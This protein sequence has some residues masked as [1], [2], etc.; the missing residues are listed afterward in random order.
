ML[1]LFSLPALADQ[2]ECDGSF[3]LNRLI[4]G[5]E[6]VEG[7]LA[8]GIERRAAEVLTVL[9]EG[10]ACLED[11]VHPRH[12]VRYG[13]ARALLAFARADE[14]ELRYWGQLALLDP[15]VRWP[16]GLEVDHPARE[17]LATLHPTTPLRLEHRGLSAPRG[18]AILID[19][20]AR[21]LPEA[22]PDAPHLVQIIDGSGL[23]VQTLWQDGV[24][25]SEALLSDTPE[26]L[27]IPWACPPPDPGLDP[28]AP[29]RISPE[30]AARRA[31]LRT[32]QRV[33]ELEARQ[34][35][36]QA[37][38]RE[39][40]RAERRQARLERRNASDGSAPVDDGAGGAPRW[41]DV[42]LE[43]V[44]PR[45]DPLEQGRSTQGC[46][47]LLLLE[48]RSMLGRLTEEQILCLQTRLSTTG[49]QTTRS[50]ISRILVA[51][52]WSRGDDHRWS[53]AIRRHLEQIDRSDADLCYLFARWLAARASTDPEAIRW[54][55]LA[56]DN[57]HRWEG[58]RRIQRVDA[59]HRIRTVVAQ[60][61]W[62]D[63]ETD[64]LQQ[65]T[66]ERIGRATFW[67]NQTKTLAR[68]WLQFALAAG[69]DS[70]LPYELCLSAA[71]TTE[72]CDLV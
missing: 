56:L 62:L 45:R 52:A 54:A 19:G 20:T 26:P 41:V 13:R 11:P 65:R 30:E 42:Y 38:Q 9:H 34:Q 29:I 67:R 49:A 63:A 59:L 22:S 5:L 58:P 50:A 39:Q 33:A 28:Y 12:L 36:Q 21:D 6:V 69:V 47:D 43:D 60:S 25:W 55:Q 44:L 46:D 17:T 37:L 23:V 61:L 18:G 35:L 57:A 51:D 48:P 8:Q 14:A 24:I 31:T 71:G 1:W 70:S 68:E 15:E 3:D 40:L 53:G 7:A 2:P 16:E 66:P 4:E 10:A 64:V 32:E 72:Y 27:P